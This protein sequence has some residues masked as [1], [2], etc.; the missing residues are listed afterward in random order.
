[1][2]LVVQLRARSLVSHLC[3][4]SIIRG[5]LKVHGSPPGYLRWIILLAIVNLGED[6]TAF[7]DINGGRC[8]RGISRYIEF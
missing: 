7:I 3:T 1:M 5:V 2:I 8:P 4:W 6:N